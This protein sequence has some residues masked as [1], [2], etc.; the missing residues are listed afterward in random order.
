MIS[1]G[2]GLILRDLE[3]HSALLRDLAGCFVDDRNQRYI[4]HTVIDGGGFGKIKGKE[5]KCWNLD[6]EG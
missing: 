6:V 2:G 1:D 5:S 4:E 3:R